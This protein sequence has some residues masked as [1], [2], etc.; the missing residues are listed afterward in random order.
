MVAFCSRLRK[1]RKS[2]HGKGFGVN[3]PSVILAGLM[4]GKGPKG[5]LPAVAGAGAAVFWVLLCLRWFDVGA[6]FRPSALD[7]CPPLLLA[8]TTL[9]LFG[10]WLRGR[11]SDLRGDGE[12]DRKGLLLAVGLA[13]LFRLPLAFQGAAGYT[14]PDGALS[15][16]VAIRIREGIERLVFVPHVPYSGSLKSHLTAALSLILDTPRAFCLVSV[17]FYALFVAAVHRLAWRSAGPGAALAAGLY[18]AFAP[19]FVTQYSLSNDGNYVEVLALGTWA[20]WISARWIDE[21]TRRPT[22]ALWAGLLLG[23]ASWCHILAVLHVAAVGLVLLLPAG[24]RA[25]RSLLWT[26]VG[27]ALGYFPALLWNAA[28]GWESLGYVVPGGQRVGASDGLGIGGRA[29]RMISDHWPVL[30]G[31]DPGYPAGLDR[32][33]AG[34]ALAGVALALIAFAKARGSGSVRRVL[35]AFTVLN[36]VVALVALPHLDGNPRYLLFLAAPISVFLGQAL[37]R[38]PW[39]FALAGLVAFGALGSLGQAASKIEEDGAWRS[40]ALGLRAEDVRWCYSDFFTA[41]RINFLT[42][43]RTVC[44]AKLGPIMTEYFYDYRRRVEAAPEAALVA[45]NH[46]YA[47]KIEKRLQ[48]LGVD[49]Q[50]RDLLRPTFLRLSRKVDPEELFPDRAFPYR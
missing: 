39:R 12:G 46:A 44:S 28:N 34:L 10:L 23:L 41:T 26:G 11:A 7:A 22:L 1:D 25:I 48:R 50:R 37:H 14:T 13:I 49:W 9:G 47:A 16:I 42:E 38:G 45:A 43:E 35:L 27:L 18:A 31:Y 32:L 24:A 29:L 36:L 33:M 21:P 20:L 8:L 6:R 5:W 17:L 2:C 19:T 15:G 30:M 3:R 4:S 40:F